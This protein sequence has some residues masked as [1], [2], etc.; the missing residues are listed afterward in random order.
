MHLLLLL[1]TADAATLTVGP[2]QA[3]RTINAAIDAAA[4]G[5]TIRVE[6]GTYAEDIDVRGRSL[7]IQSLYGPAQTVLAPTNPIKLDAGLLEGFAVSPAPATA[8]LIASG[9]PTI[10]EL[11]I[12][13]P[14]TYG[15]SVTGGSPLVEEVG[16]W[17]AGLHAFIVTGGTPTLQRSVAYA[18]GSYGFQVKAASTLRNC[19]AIGGTY[20][21]V[22]ETAASTATN[23]VAV[24]ASTAG[25]AALYTSTVTNS[26]FEDNTV[27]LRC[28]NG[29]VPVFPN[30][31]AYNTNDTTNCT[32]TVLAA[33][34]EVDP[35]FSSW[36]AALPLEQIDLRPTGTSPMRNAGTGLD[37]DGSVAD[38]GA[39]GGSEN[40]WH[41]R[42][43]DG[44]P[45]LFDCD[46]RNADT[47]PLAEESGDGLDNDCDD[48][49]DEDVPV[50]TG[51][52]D[53]GEDT[54][55]DTGED[56]GVDTDEPA[57]GDLDGD[58]FLASEDCD[59]H[60]RATYPGA[61]ELTDGVDNDCDGYAD[62]GTG[63]GDDDMDG[64]SEIDGDCDDTRADR[65]P[66]ADDRA[67]DGLDHDCDGVPFDSIGQ[68]GDGDGYFD[69]S[70]DCDDTNAQIHPGASE[71][72]D[73]VDNDC[74]GRADEDALDH[75]GDGDGQSPSQ[76][77]CDDANAVVY[78]GA[79][80]TPDDFVDQDCSGTDNYDADRDGDPSPASGGTDCDDQRS[81]VYPGA[82]E[83]CGDNADND[84]DGTFE[85]D[86]ETTGAPATTDD[87]CS[88]G[89]RAPGAGG[90]LAAVALVAA[91]FRRRRGPSSRL[92][93]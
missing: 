47:Y 46:D 88:C 21:F 4:D 51:G 5:D 50:D 13:G 73:G 27:A 16:V 52:D 9:S 74:D 90:G 37:S 32:G 81:T 24:G 62:E 59:E 41:D 18:T 6:P 66:N 67:E 17:E 48:I 15:V 19:I 58:G 43:G 44:Y 20:G 49:V 68:D 14:A 84:C 83:L 80:D 87:G 12:E 76:G 93:S 69:S 30:G 33:V 2:T 34:T 78:F 89:S 63:A 1:A 29:A 92:C 70:G 25:V 7:F 40:D 10:R 75:D 38:L 35:A 31:I 71:S 65:H 56:T 28:F 3:Y 61:R 57:G 91:L 77:D 23:V 60:N 85:E 42:D 54:G 45:V 36:S 26:V 55:A 79:I 64:Y 8:V 72:T 86:C 53:T 82:P 39:F 22:F 11:H